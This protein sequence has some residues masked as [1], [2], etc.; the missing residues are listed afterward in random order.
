MR[1]VSLRAIFLIGFVIAMPIL[2]LPSVARR[3]D[4]WIY[5]PPPTEHAISPLTSELAQVIEPQVAERASPAS[6]DEIESSLASRQ[7]PGGL[8]AP[9]P[10]P[11]LLSP[12]PAFPPLVSTPQPESGTSQSEPSIGP[13]SD[14]A[15]ARLQ[16]IRGE[17][18]RLGA[19]YI[20]LET[21]DGGGNY[22]FHC[23]VRVDEKTRYTRP[24][25]AAGTDPLAAAE[26]VLAEVSSWRT[27]AQP[28]TQPTGTR[29]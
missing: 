21:T 10:T 20:V 17:L 29:R 22:R 28:T 23:D 5:G 3:L 16:Q 13:L 12:L 8:D 19:D 4:D 15:A 7:S 9:S 18:E 11:P 25:E 6:F 1:S 14:A 24:F 26:R 27:A 2:A